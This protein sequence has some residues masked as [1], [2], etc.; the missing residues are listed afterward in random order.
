M[1]F[2]NLTFFRFPT[3]VAKSL[4]ELDARLE[5]CR[6]KPVGPSELMSRGFVPPMGRDA[7]AMSH[8]IGDGIWITLGGEDRL[9]PAAV[10]ND[11]LGRKIASIVAKRL[12]V[13]LGE[14]GHRPDALLLTRERYTSHET[15]SQG[16]VTLDG[17]ENASEQYPPCCRPVPGDRI[18]GYLLM[19]LE[20]FGDPAL[21]LAAYNA[22]PDAVARHGERRADGQRPVLDAV[23]VDK[24]AT[25]ITA[26]DPRRQFV[27][28]V[29]AVQLASVA[30]HRRALW[31][32]SP[33]RPAPP[34][35][36]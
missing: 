14:H 9:L 2:R 29:E 33:S 35:P 15:L 26:D 10:V 31:K 11:A 34:P 22:G 6:L 17:S 4:A 30:L 19:M 12:V 7:E 25:E 27:A 18:V 23:V 16:A 21:A 5:E 24:L 1:F 32:S 20:Q 8:R 13:L 28:E 36:C 3:T